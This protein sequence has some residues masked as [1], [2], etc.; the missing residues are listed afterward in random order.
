[1]NHIRASVMA[2]ATLVTVLA[3]TASADAHRHIARIEIK[4]L[5]REDHQQSHRVALKANRRRQNGSHAQP[6]ATLQIH[7][8]IKLRIIASQSLSRRSF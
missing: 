3:W 5:G 8:R 7:A 1:M 2:L 4:G 6:P